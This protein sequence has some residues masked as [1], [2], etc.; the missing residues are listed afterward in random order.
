MT[1]ELFEINGSTLKVTSL[2]GHRIS[3]RKIE[4]KA[5]YGSRKVIVPGKS[6]TEISKILSGEIDDLVDLYF[7]NNHILF[8]F[9]QTTVVSRL[10]KRNRSS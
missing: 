3:I 10:E 2:D 6:L 9:D 5:E 4:L 8:E 1:G 7:T